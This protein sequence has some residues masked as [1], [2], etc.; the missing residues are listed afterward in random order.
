MINTQH[1]SIVSQERRRG[2]KEGGRDGRKEGVMVG[3]RERGEK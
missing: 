3:G 2:G 1:V